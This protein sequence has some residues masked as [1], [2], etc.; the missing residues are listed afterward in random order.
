MEIVKKTVNSGLSQA[1]AVAKLFESAKRL[2]FE[3]TRQKDLG[4]GTVRI[5]IKIN[6]GDD[7][8][9]KK[10]SPEKTERDSGRY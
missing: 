3:A 8:Q 6:E 2:G 7:G 4:D 1:E 9:I 10:L 5:L